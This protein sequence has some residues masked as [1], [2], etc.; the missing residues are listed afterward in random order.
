MKH[1]KIYFAIL[2]FSFLGS[3][4][5]QLF[6]QGDYTAPAEPAKSW[7]RGMGLNDVLENG[8]YK[9]HFF[10]DNQNTVKLI[11]TKSG[12]SVREV[13][14]A[15]HVSSPFVNQA[16]YTNA[17]NVEFRL[18][19]TGQGVGVNLSREDRK[20]HPYWKKFKV[21]NSDVLVEESAYMK[22]ESDGRFMIYS[23][24]GGIP[25]IEF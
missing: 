8:D 22:L 2:F 7:S 14:T 17:G 5:N 11:I 15:W 4:Q 19:T 16:I 23:E 12:G 20:N 18:Q 6:A 25:V 1:L 24:N 3:T 9:A 10:R 13:E 21:L